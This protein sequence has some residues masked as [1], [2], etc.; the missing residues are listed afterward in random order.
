MKRGMLGLPEE[1]GERNVGGRGAG[2]TKRNLSTIPSS[3]RLW[4]CTMESQIL[5]IGML[6]EDDADLQAG[7]ELQTSKD[8]CADT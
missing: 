3:V 1:A 4:C 8:V 6:M 5:I 7:T 2:G